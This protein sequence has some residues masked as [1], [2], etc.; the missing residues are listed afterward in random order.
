[1]KPIAI[2]P[3]RAGSKRIPNK[4]IKD[5][6]G[7][8]LIAY[9]IQAAHQSK[10]FEHIIVSTDSPHIAS[11][12]KQYGA[13]VPFL[14]DQCLSDD[15]TP[16]LDV[17]IDA[18][19]Q[20]SIQANTPIC[21]IY[22]TAPLLQSTHLIQAYQLLESKSPSYVFIA[23]EFSFTPLRG[24]ILEDQTLEMLYPEHQNIRSQDLPKIYHDGGQFYF[25]LARTFIDQIPIFSPTSLPIIVPNHQ[26]QDI[27]TPEDF[28]LA[29]LKYQLLHHAH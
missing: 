15:F 28:E 10:L 3:A 21:C 9:S 25:G 19:K 29:K 12:A 18:I 20:C 1:M 2:I 7:Q 27:D 13:I 14:R 8:P 4:N 5:F 23:T 11:I 24:F 6:L 22:P 26:I 17:I 16:T